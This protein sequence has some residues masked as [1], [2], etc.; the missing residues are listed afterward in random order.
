[1][2]IPAGKLVL[3]IAFAY[4]LIALVAY[5]AQRK[6]TYFPS[7]E[8]VEPA[9]VGLAGVAERIIETPD[10]ERV[11]AWYGK[12]AAG[13]P[14]IL[15]FHGNGGNLALRSERIRRYLDRGQG[16]LMMSYRGYSGS[17]GHPSEAANL[18]DAR[19]AYQMLIEEGVAPSDI[20]LYGES[21]GSGVATRIAFENPVGGL[22]L[23]SPFTSAAD[24]G[25]RRYPFLPVRLMMW[26]RYEVLR[27]I[28]KI[29]APLLIIHGERDRI[30]PFEMGQAVFA[31]ANEPKKLVSFANGGH[32]DHSLHGSF[33]A[34]QDWIEQLR[35]HPAQ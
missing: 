24:V 28:A 5:L 21:L 16:M 15:Y 25:A 1:M 3:L 34:I 30:V 6:L 20:I 13:Q 14:T 19:L 26:D 9:A 23:D 2:L 22:I 18:A 11:V 33:E 31:A 8:R 27:Y 17:S 12:A 4:V 10:G 7:P 35:Q 32:N 29:R